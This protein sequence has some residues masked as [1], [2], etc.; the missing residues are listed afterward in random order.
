MRFNGAL[1][2]RSATGTADGRGQAGA[3]RLRQDACSSGGRLRRAEAGHLLRSK[4]EKTAEISLPHPERPRVWLNVALVECAR[5]HRVVERTS[6]VSG[7]ARRAAGRPRPLRDRRCRNA[8][9]AS[10]SGPFGT[11]EPTPYCSRPPGDV[12]GGAPVG[13][14]PARRHASS[15]GQRRP[16]SYS[17]DWAMLVAV[18]PRQA[19]AA[20]PRR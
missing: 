7:T 16:D 8:Q 10:R 14:G 12:E 6:P 9:R 19:R 4:G 1:M 18:A 20:R 5:C 3:H 2:P 13:I 11:Q 17:V 15:G